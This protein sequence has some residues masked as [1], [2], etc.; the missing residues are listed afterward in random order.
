VLEGARGCGEV[1]WEIEVGQGAAHVGDGL[2]DVVVGA[3][4][5]VGLAGQLDG[6]QAQGSGEG[7]DRG[8]MGDAVTGLDAGDVGAR[9]RGPVGE[10]V[11]GEVATF[12]G[13]CQ[14]WSDTGAG[15]V[16]DHR[17]SRRGCCPARLERCRV[18]D[19]EFSRI[20]STKR[21]PADYY[22]VII[23]VTAEEQR[24]RK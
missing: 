21:L 11:L 1:G 16:L 22:P 7:G 13:A 14:A 4:V 15:R 20:S 24:R 19:A 17:A 8:G 5:A 23:S 10:A 3:G 12:T 9:E 2:V 6:V 18:V